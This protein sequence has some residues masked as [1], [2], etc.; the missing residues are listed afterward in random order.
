MQAIP[1]PWSQLIREVLNL[2]SESRMG[3][4]LEWSS[5]RGRDFQCVATALYLMEKKDVLT[6][7]FPSPIV[8]D[9]W[10]QRVTPPAKVF[11]ERVVDTFCV[12][13]NL[14]LEK[15]HSKV[16]QKP[17]RVSPIEFVMIAVLIDLY[18]TKYTLSQ[19]AIAISK[20]RADVRQKHA[21]VRANSRVTKT[22]LAFI[23]DKVPGLMKK[24]ENGEKTALQDV[25][26]MPP[27]SAPRENGKRKRARGSSLES[28][29]SDDAKPLKS[30]VSPVKKTART[31]SG[32]ASG[33]KAA[34]PA[35][36]KTSVDRMSVDRPPTP[37]A[38]SSR[39][40]GPSIAAIS[41]GSRLPAKPASTVTTM[42]S[43]PRPTGSTGMR[44]DRLAAMRA[45]KAAT[46]GIKPQTPTPTPP[47]RAP[48]RQ[49]TSD[50]SM[51]PPSTMSTLT[52]VDMSAVQNALQ[53]TTTGQ[54]MVDAQS[55]PG[56][57]P[58]AQ[59]Q[60]STVYN[61][62][63][64]QQQPQMQ[65]YTQPTTSVD[66]RMHPSRQAAMGLPTGM[67]QSTL[68]PRGAPHPEQQPPYSYQG[69][70]AGPYSG[71]PPPAGGGAVPPRHRD[72][73]TRFDWQS[74]AKTNGGG[75]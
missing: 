25:R 39:A 68:P 60:M 61:Q 2:M 58:Q 30:K 40:T 17:S 13:R 45:A 21:D 71:P 50:A 23:A 11:K 44:N 5:S 65:Q 35:L 27:P 14:V 15:T 46:S 4:H 9:R 36:S 32:V 12:F 51:P 7:T 28:E 52:G 54:M 55:W 19:L 22:L 62:L 59:T 29:G 57:V 47:P 66:P 33:S 74:E 24:P 38:S 37:Q 31:V 42:A 20:M 56:Q 49:S 70:N 10:L 72:R 67:D 75:H 53:R 34:S 16:F 48:S 64:Q 43:T 3:E 73:V 26:S 8:L 1:G 6:K 63:H 41:G 69:P 18:M